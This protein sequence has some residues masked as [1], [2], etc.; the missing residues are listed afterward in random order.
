MIRYHFRGMRAPTDSFPTGSPEWLEGMS[1]RLQSGFDATERNGGRYMLETLREIIGHSPWLF[2]P[3][4]HPAGN[5][6][7]YIEGVTGQPYEATVMIVEGLSDKTLADRL[8]E[9][10]RESVG[11]A[12]KHGTNQHSEG[13]H[14]NVMS[15]QGNAATYTLARLKR[16]HPDLAARVV[17]GELTANAAA[18]Q[19]GFRRKTWSAPDDPEQLAQ[20][21]AKRYPGW[22]LTKK[23]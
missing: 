3:I 15:S 17:A 13:G 11:K 14:D 23:G 1:S 8:K 12:T 22:Q 4:D 20:A 18:I 16:D 10:A 9:L 21:V 5:A 2:I 6:K 7:D 19:A